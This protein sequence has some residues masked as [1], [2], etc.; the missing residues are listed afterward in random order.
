MDYTG[1]GIQNWFL[2][3]IELFIY[4]VKRP[5][6]D[7]LKEILKNHLFS[8]WIEN[9]CLCIAYYIAFTVRTIKLKGIVKK[10]LSHFFPHLR[11]GGRIPKLT[12]LNLSSLVGLCQV[13]IASGVLSKK[14]NKVQSGNKAVHSKFFCAIPFFWSTLKNLW[15]FNP[16]FISGWEPQNVVPNLKFFCWEPRVAA[17]TPSKNLG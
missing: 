9:T 11:G 10:C 13:R 15:I 2:K 4:Y 7:L 8:P 1:N 6:R 16:N 14:T 12:Q 5:L 17:P 3:E